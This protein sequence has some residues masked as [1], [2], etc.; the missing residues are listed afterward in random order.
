MRPRYDLLVIGGGPGGAIAARTAAEKGLSVCVAEKRPAIGTPV[1][2]AEGIGREA[3]A[4]LVTPDPCWISAEMS[5]AELVAPDGTSLVLES[6]IAGG[7]VGY[8][9]DRKVFDRAL[10]AQAADSGADVMVKT[11][12]IAPLINEGRVQGA[13][14]E[15]RGK[16]TPVEAGVVIAADGVE[17]KFSRWC[18]IDTTV[19]QKEMM[20]C[21]QYLMTG[22][23]IDE[24]TTGF[25]FGNTVAPEGYAWVFPKGN[26][27]ANV[28]IGISGRKSGA[29]HRAID[30]LDRFVQSR[31]PRGK[32]IELVV[33]GVPVCQPLACSVMDGLMVVG[34]AARVVDPLTGGGIYHAM[35]TGRLAAV[36]GA[37][38][39]AAG[40]V[41][42][43]VLMAYDRGWRDAKFG[44]SLTRN[45]R[46][47]EYFMSLPDAKL[48][49]L[50][51]SAA[52]LDLENFST[53]ALIKE[54]VFRHPALGAELAKMKLALR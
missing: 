44:R 54:L 27:S 48:N 25:Y 50:A 9:L 13:V 28:G 20:S 31:F 45:F 39:I 51:E 22:L 38:A 37:D 52:T 11:R 18:G 53:T 12:A 26:G 23:D 46:F 15:H 6:R 41:S 49:A 10:M 34:D 7:K 17:S 14:L 43:D 36:T 24:H 30:Y 47:K 16:A 2:C 1:R 40:D 42:R 33:G 32:I 3:L 21:A 29:G 4:E 35:F 8:V 19:P 5:R